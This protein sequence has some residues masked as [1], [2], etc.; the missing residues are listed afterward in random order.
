MVVAGCGT[1][2]TAPSLRSSPE[3]DAI[4][5][6]DSIAVPPV[7]LP[8]DVH[9]ERVTRE[10]FEELT[11]LLALKGYVLHRVGRTVVRTASDLRPLGD[12][13]PEELAAVLPDGGTHYLL[14]WIDALQGGRGGDPQKTAYVRVSAALIDRS[15]RRVLWRNFANQS[16]ATFP[17]ITPFSLEIARRQ[18]QAPYVPPALRQSEFERSLREQAELGQMMASLV[19]PVTGAMRALLSSFPERE[20]R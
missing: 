8:G 3:S 4:R 9:D 2:P 5:R 10:A 19:S 7:M 1:A 20:M 16:S 17:V 14:C 12:L 13:S 18:A 15:G 6:V 11:L